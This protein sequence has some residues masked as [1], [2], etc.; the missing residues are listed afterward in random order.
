MSEIHSSSWHWLACVRLLIPLFHQKNPLEENEFRFDF[1][2]S[3]HSKFSFTREAP[4]FIHESEYLAIED[5]IL[6][7]L[8]DVLQNCTILNRYTKTMMVTLRLAL[9][10]GYGHETL[11]TTF[12]ML[13]TTFIMFGGWIFGAYIFIIISNV[14]MASES[15][16]SKYE[17]IRREINAYCLANHLS[18]EL[19][20]RIRQ[21]VEIKYQKHYFNEAKIL[22]SI[23]SNLRTEIMLNSCS[24]LV[25]KVP[26]FREIPRLILE[27][28]VSCLKLEIFFPGDIIIQAGTFG[29]CMFFISSGTAEIISASGELMNTLSDGS[30][31]GEISLLTRGNKRIASV[32]AVEVCETYKLNRKDFRKVIEPHQE[33]LR[34]LEQIALQRIKAVSTFKHEKRE[35]E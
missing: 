27:Q 17:E 30:H 9:Q 18:E 22:K 35:I 16:S 10:S 29:E 31:F 14:F 12:D 20:M 6:E 7:D 4:E 25:S 21:A 8:S 32:K 33:L 3:F 23:P 13:M 15:S 1:S 26:L 28:I 19:T 34:Y 24:H 11:N 5:V 2:R